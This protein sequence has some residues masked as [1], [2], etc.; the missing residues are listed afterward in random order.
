MVPAVT[1]AS[2]FDAMFSASGSGADGYPSPATAAQTAHTLSISAWEK[3][4][5]LVSRTI[6]D[7]R[8]SSSVVTSV[9]TRGT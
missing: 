1:N 8:S 4:V 5:A 9:S 7:S 2:T 6:G 3:N